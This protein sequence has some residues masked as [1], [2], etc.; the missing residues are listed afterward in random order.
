MAAP[1]APECFTAGGVA[2]HKVSE[3]SDVYS[4]A[5]IMWEMLTG[6]RPWAEYSHQM[7]II[8]QVVQCDRRPPWPKYCPAPEAVRKL[9][10]ACWRR[11][12][13]ERPSAADVLKRL[14]AMLRQ[15]PSPPPDLTPP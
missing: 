9:V 3:K 8:Y 15:L 6:M 12:P 4:L 1:L 11:N 14:E 10:T 7:A 2:G 13:R 5:V